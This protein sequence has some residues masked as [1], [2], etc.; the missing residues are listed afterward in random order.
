M[1]FTETKLPGVLIIDP[2]VHRDSRGFFVENYNRRRYSELQGLD[3][4]FVQDNHSRSS[5]DV[6]RGL[7]LQR[8]HPQGKLVN[9]VSGRVWDVAVDINPC[10]PTFCQWVGVELSE[11]NQRQLYIPPGYAHGFCVLSDQ[12]DFLYKCTEFHYPEDEW[13]LLWSDAEFA[14]D[15]PVSKPVLSKK[16]ANNL[17]LREF[18]DS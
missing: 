17:T 7:H 15:W 5:R 1:K 18:L 2:D 9:V 12:A 10:S 3:V 16:D 8:E 13:G 11:G 6:L 4:D 14:I